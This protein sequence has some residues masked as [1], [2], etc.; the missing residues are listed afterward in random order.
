ME[1]NTVIDVLKKAILMERQGK[2]FYENVA[3]RT[4][5]EGVKR[6][7]GIM[8][9]EEQVHIQFLSQEFAHYNKSHEFTKADLS[10]L[11]QEDHFT[12]M[13]LSPEVKKQ[14]SA[15]SYE[16][17]AIN[18]AIDMETK[19]I[20]Y[21]SSTAKA[22]NDPREKEIFNWLAQ[23]EQGHHKILNELNRELME[24]VWND[25]NFWPF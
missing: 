13:I 20:E 7:F 14:I 21:Y 8:A 4:E 15:A 12:K 16:A 17:A 2:A 3:L 23:W 22:T 9:S 24:E 10:G 6:I 11:S 18:A 1:S 19:A 5:S 25:N